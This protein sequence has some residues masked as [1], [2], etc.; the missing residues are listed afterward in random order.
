MIDD[1]VVMEISEFLMF[2]F[3]LDFLLDEIFLNSGVE[4]VV[5][6]LLDFKLVF[7]EK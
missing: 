5:D 7:R 6:F 3:G 1:D 4:E 2:F